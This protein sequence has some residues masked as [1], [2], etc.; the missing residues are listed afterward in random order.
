MMNFACLQFSRACEETRHWFAHSEWMTPELNFLPKYQ[1][2]LQ[3]RLLNA[4][5]F[6]FFLRPS[7][8]LIL[9]N[10]NYFHSNSNEWLA[11]WS[12]PACNL[13]SF[14]QISWSPGGESTEYAWAP[15]N[16]ILCV[17]APLKLTR[18]VNKKKCSPRE[19][20]LRSSRAPK[21]YLE[22]TI[23]ARN[24]R[25]RLEPRIGW[26]RNAWFSKLVNG[27]AQKEWA[28]IPFNYENACVQIIWI[29]WAIGENGGEKLFFLTCVEKN[30]DLNKCLRS[31]PVQP[32]AAKHL[33]FRS[34]DAAWT[35]GLEFL[36][37]RSRKTGCF[38]SHISNRPVGNC[39][40]RGPDPNSVRTGSQNNFLFFSDSRKVKRRWAH[41]NLASR[42]S[43]GPHLGEVLVLLEFR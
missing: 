25:E 14:V 29:D 35:R 10:W 31:T 33:A 3:V 4:P 1:S 2:N 19:I 42:T 30:D 8:A 13:S 36:G 26:T 43:Q 17:H 9:R 41:V 27:T 34:T 15:R 20:P 32:P 6:F 11:L 37:K 39:W 7:F 40:N 24:S 18:A 23:P 21:E 12:S 16:E 28:C 5:M 38:L 22:S